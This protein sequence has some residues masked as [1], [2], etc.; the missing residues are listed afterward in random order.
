MEDALFT[1]TL[2]LFQGYI[3]AS[4]RLKSHALAGL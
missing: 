4:D 2:N 1:Q 3:C